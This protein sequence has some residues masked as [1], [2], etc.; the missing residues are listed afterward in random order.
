MSNRYPFSHLVVGYQADERSDQAL[1]AALD[2][3]KRCS[4]S[5]RLV[6]AVDIPAPEWIAGDPVEVAARSSTILEATLQ[7]VLSHAGEQLVGAGYDGP[8]V[9]EI[10][11]VVPG[12]PG[13]VIIDAARSEDADII[14][15]GPHERRGF[16]DFGRTARTVLAHAPDGVWVQPGPYEPVRSILVAV[17][18]SEHSLR[19]LDV[20][21]ALAQHLDARLTVLNAFE[22]PDFAYPA[23]GGMI[24][25]PSYVIDEVRDAARQGFEQTMAEQSFEGLEPDLVFVEGRPVEAILGQVADGGHDLVVLGSHGRTGLSS[26]VLGNVAYGVMREASV[27]TLALRH[28]GRDWLV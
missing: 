18:L 9:E 6:T 15:L 1:Q 4:S 22:P 26:V 11:S 23:G 10:L 20:A 19:A 21:R 3:R 7:N 5:L 17:D 2:I 24:P 13:R 16:L 12:P 25:G 8:P 27:P 14:F 28:P